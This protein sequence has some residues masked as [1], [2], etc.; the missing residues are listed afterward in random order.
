MKTDANSSSGTAE[1]KAPAPHPRNARERA[2]FLLIL[3]LFVT[4]AVWWA[5]TVPYTPGRIERVAPANAWVIS[6]HRAL[7]NRLDSLLANGAVR[8]ALKNGGAD[9]GQL[10]AALA[11]PVTKRWLRRLLNE[12]TLLAYTKALPMSGQPALL[13][14]SWVGGWSQKLRWYLSLF[15]IPGL[16]RV[17]RIHTGF[18][19][20]TEIEA[21]APGTVLSFAVVEGMVLACLSAD[22]EA[23]HILADAAGAH[24]RYPALATH[25]LPSPAPPAGDAADRAWL[26]VPRDGTAG[27][28]LFLAVAVTEITDK[29]LAGT[30]HGVPA[31][32]NAQPAHTLHA[33]RGLYEPWG[34]IADV[35]VTAPVSLLKHAVSRLDTPW[36]GTVRHILDAAGDKDSPAFACL[37]GGAFT[38]KLHFGII[39]PDVPTLLIGL[40]VESRADALAK[41][42]TIVDTLNAETQWGL[43]PTTS[44]FK[45]YTLGILEST[46]NTLYAKFPLQERAA[47]AAADG[48][49]IFASNAK[50]LIKLLAGDADRP[51]PPAG[52]PPELARAAAYGRIEIK[53][54]AQTV[55]KLM[56]IALLALSLSDADNART[57]RD[58]LRKAKGF[59]K[60]ALI[61][62]RIVLSVENKNGE[63]VIHWRMDG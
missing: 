16:Q 17:E 32:P 15:D 40:P 20:R 21:G 14:A 26:R 12:E 58:R 33:I 55:R 29:R 22:P 50:I 4:A 37:L 43:V 1:T 28:S 6:R 54:T 25:C 13:I 48:L 31:L 11:D 5:L 39:R 57:Q 3:V 45:P 38:G 44:T 52:P 60:K 36:A 2:L 8:E 46:R 24:P 9:I 7:G 51:G 49:L 34:P 30:V 18:V 59:L 63:S 56:D 41:A 27:E 47:Y 35:F 23:I 10:E 62:E 53:P 61:A 19:W 42:S